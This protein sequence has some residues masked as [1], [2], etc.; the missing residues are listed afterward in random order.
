M[1]KSVI[2]ALAAAPL[3]ATAAIA[4]PYVNVEANSAYVGNDYEA[5]LLETHVGFEG[6]VG[7][8]ADWYIQGGPAFTFVD[9]ED[10]TDTEVSGKVGI[11]FDVTES[12]NIYG[13]VWAMTAGEVDFDEDLTVGLKSG[14]KIKF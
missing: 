3:F 12:V 6:P 13:E 10:D 5:T 14:V 4:G 7:P 11:G 2:A 9:G 8:S 1:F